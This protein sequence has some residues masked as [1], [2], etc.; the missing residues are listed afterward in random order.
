MSEVP[1]RELNQHTARVLARV[2]RGERI[3]ITERGQ[4]VARIVP[5]HDNPLSDLISSGKLQPATISGP[6]PRP[7]GPV[8]MDQEAGQVLRG[9]RD[10]ER[11]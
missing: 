6:A 10:A 4:V 7:T 9:L 11:Y 1:V 2:K 8:R 5:A 3:D